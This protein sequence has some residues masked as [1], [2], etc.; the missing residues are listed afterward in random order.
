MQY[1]RRVIWIIAVLSFISTWVL[2]WLDYHTAPISFPA[3]LQLR[4]PDIGYWI[5]AVLYSIPVFLFY[6]FV[7]FLVAAVD[8]VLIWAGRKTGLTK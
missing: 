4:M 7:F 1:N 8:R 5:M 3:Y 6:S 2:L